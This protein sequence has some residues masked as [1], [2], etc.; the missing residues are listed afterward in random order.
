MGGQRRS[1]FERGA[2]WEARLDGPASARVSPRL[3]ADFHEVRPEDGALVAP[4]M[5]VDPAILQ[6]RFEGSRRCFAAAVDGRVAAYG[7]VS[8]GGEWVGELERRFRLK[9]G[10]VYIWDCVT[11]PEYRGQ[12]MYS[13][14]LSFIL[15]TLRAEGQQRAW[16]GAS[17]DNRVSQSGM[18]NAGFRPVVWAIYGRIFGLHAF[19]V[20]GY[21][22]VSRQT[23]ADARWLMSSEHERVCGPLLIWM[24]QPA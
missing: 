3:P 24:S 19:W 12:G 23:I 7:W 5:G 13:A 10:E 14:L 16:I 8:Y 4:S 15:D 6:R 18:A 9:A 2:L 20:A 22:G 21:H 11:L 17:L 1:A